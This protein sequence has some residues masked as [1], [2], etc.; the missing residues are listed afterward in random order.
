MNE[1]K[2]KITKSIDVFIKAK[3][4]EVNLNQPLYAVNWFSTKVAWVYHFYNFLASKSV[5]KIGGEGFFKGKIVKTILDKNNSRRDLILIVRY[6]NG[7][8]FKN[9]MEDTYFKIVS[10]FRMIAVKDFSFGFT[11]KQS[12]SESKLN[13]NLFYVVHHFK[14]TNEMIYAQFDKF[15]SKDVSIK[16]SGKMIAEL[17]SKKVDKKVE[18]VPNIMDGIVIYE[19]KSEEKILNMITKNEYQEIIKGLDS[20]FIGTVKRIL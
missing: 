10:L 2:C 15:L 1:I 14:T 5:K 13:D 19:S 16:Y 9:L 20:S 17:Q 3:K 12:I 6:P 11:S 18:K 7:N 8:G 4:A